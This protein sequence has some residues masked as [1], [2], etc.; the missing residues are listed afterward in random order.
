MKIKDLFQ[1]DIYRK[2][3]EVIKVDQAEQETVRSELE[4]YIVTDS[5]K[6]TSGRPSTPTNLPGPLLLKELAY[7]YPG[8]SAPVNPLLP[9]SWATSLPTE[10]SLERRRPIFSP[11]KSMIPESSTCSRSSIK[12]FRLTR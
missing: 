3:E 6:G 7:G 1:K 12:P 8:F 11:P 9:R 10:K 4:E 5:I 2:I